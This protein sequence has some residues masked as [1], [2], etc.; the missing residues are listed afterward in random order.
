MI[1]TSWTYWNS[2]IFHVVANNVDHL[3]AVQATTAVIFPRCGPQHGKII[4]VL[5]NNAEKDT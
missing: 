3:S 4:G 5:N 2:A 1:S